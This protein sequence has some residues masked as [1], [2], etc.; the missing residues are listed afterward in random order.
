MKKILKT[1]SLLMCGFVLTT[2]FTACG[3]DDENYQKNSNIP[4]KTSMDCTLKVDAE[5]LNSF[6]FF[7]SYYDDNGKVQT[8]QMVWKDSKTNL[9]VINLSKPAKEWKK[10]VTI[11]KLPSTLGLLFEVKPK[12]G[13][14][15]NAGYNWLWGYNMILMAMNA[16]GGVITDKMWGHENIF[17][18]PEGM[19]EEIFNNG[20]GGLLNEIYTFQSNGAIT[21]SKWE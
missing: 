3:D 18:I 19:F 11:T 4:T 12:A 7:V 21:T 5:A 8:E 6:D 15:T 1:I 10:T 16:N 9:E 20:R 14:D 13:I 2:G 17:T